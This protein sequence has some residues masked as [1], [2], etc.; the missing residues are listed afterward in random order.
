M[1]EQ[2]VTTPIHAIAKGEHGI[3]LAPKDAG[4]TSSDCLICNPYASSGWLPISEYGPPLCHCGILPAVE[5]PSHCGWR[6]LKER[7]K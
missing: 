7:T 1:N 5:C 2:I 6:R 3:P 4:V